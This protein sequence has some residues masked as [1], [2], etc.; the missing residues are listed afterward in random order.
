MGPTGPK[1]TQMDNMWPLNNIVALTKSQE[2]RV[3]CDVIIYILPFFF[4][5]VLFTN[6]ALSVKT[7]QTIL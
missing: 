7:T 4:Y 3:P 5:I 2:M 1:N 6:E